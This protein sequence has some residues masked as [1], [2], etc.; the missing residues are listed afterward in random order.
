[1][2]KFDVKFILYNVYE[3]S[4]ESESS[5]DTLSLYISNQNQHLLKLITL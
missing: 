1:M 2:Q 3:F 5:V 4:S